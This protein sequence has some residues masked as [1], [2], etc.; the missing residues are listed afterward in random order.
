M[1]TLTGCSTTMA[2]GAIKEFYCGMDGKPGAYAPVAWSRHD[3]AETVRQVK[4]NN[5]VYDSVC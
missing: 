2:T 1:L 3:T 5:A 4:A